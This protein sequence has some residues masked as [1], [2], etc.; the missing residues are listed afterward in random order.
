MAEFLFYALALV[1]LCGAAGVVLAKSPMFS[2][3]SLLASFFAL[4]VIYLLM[5]F[6]FMAAVQIVVYAGAILVLFL[7]VIMLLD[8]GHMG[9]KVEFSTA[10]FR[11]PAARIGAV[12]ALALALAGLIAVQRGALQQAAGA[13]AETGPRDGLPQLAE[14]LFGRYGL[15]FQATGMLL[16]VTMVA[17]V[18]L[19]KRDRRKGPG[20][21]GAQGGE[22]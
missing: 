21:Q 12:V 11:S 2:V 10:M 14:A 22:R 20:S 8:L 7:F 18:A 19:A 1:A 4:S 17:V 3:L 16:L 6:P 13:A 15:A 9:S 5:S